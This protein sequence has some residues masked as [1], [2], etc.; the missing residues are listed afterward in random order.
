MTPQ[1][2]RP[3][4]QWLV[5]IAALVGL[6]AVLSQPN[7]ILPLSD[8]VQYW[9]SGTANWQGG[10]PYDEATLLRVAEPL[11][12]D[13][14]A[15]LVT[16]NP[17][18][19][20]TPAMVMALLPYGWS[21]AVYVLVAFFIMVA[22]ADWAWQ[23]YGGPIRWRW[24]SWVIILTFY[25]TLYGLK[26]GQIVPLVMLGVVIVLHFADNPP[27]QFW[28]GWGV[29]L[30]LIKPHITYLLVLALILWAV[31]G[32]R[33]LVLVGMATSILAFLAG[34][35]LINPPVLGHFV[36]MVLYHPPN[37]WV[38]ATL[39]TP[40]RLWLGF[41]QSYSLQFVPSLLGMLWLAWFEWRNASHWSWRN[42]A[43]VILLA[44]LVTTAYGWIYDH[45]VVFVAF[46]QL[47][48]AALS[49]RPWRWPQWLSLGAG[50]GL[51][52]WVLFY[53]NFINPYQFTLWWLSSAMLIWYG[54]ARQAFTLSTSSHEPITL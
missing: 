35:V 12:W 26:H 7:P 42:H 16:F 30:L 27:R 20:L 52:V 11:G 1:R 34:P 23:Y 53:Q 48:V 40:I 39:S 22:C 45:P 29:P 8:Y 15:P 14:T 25:G 36:D 17:P 41:E 46:I 49:N 33:W 44:S 47:V 24:V 54:L 2:F 21:R 37:Q 31:F 51:N 43:P 32:K 19:A 4:V 3:L 13:M 38:T 6:V 10:N 5:V 50:V 9:A 18:W 28:A